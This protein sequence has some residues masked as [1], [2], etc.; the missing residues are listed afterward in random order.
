VGAVRAALVA[1][2]LHVPR[3]DHRDLVTGGPPLSIAAAADSGP[4]PVLPLDRPDGVA[5]LW[6]PPNTV[7]PG[8]R[9]PVVDASRSVRSEDEEPRLGLLRDVL[10][11]VKW[12]LS[13]R[14]GWLVGMGINLI[15]ALIYVGSTRFAPNVRGDLRIANIGLV[16]VWWVLANV[17]NTN[18]LGSDS[19][20]VVASLEDGDSLS[21]ILAIKNISLAIFLTPVAVLISVLVRVVV[22][23]WRLLPHALLAD[24]GAIFLWLGLGCV[25]SVVMP[26]RPI[27]V[28]QR[29]QRRRH[30]A[31]W[32]LC[33]ALPYVLVFLVVP[34]L[35][36]PYV[37]IYH[38]KAVG[39][40][41]ANFVVYS[42]L[43]MALGAMYWLVGLVLASW[44]GR[45]NRSRLL[46]DLR[47][48][49]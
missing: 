36:L 34:I 44:Y 32:V 17:I 48:P 4:S 20:R 12:T 31:R 19:E 21:R 40:Y 1:L 30:A 45:R 24:L 41:Q 18:Q 6:D 23:R 33:Q 10:D 29:W 37:A 7:E 49:D 22:D 14:R 39:P 42:L 11:E 3:T 2:P 35:S 9:D 15:L 8:I 38:E 16:V 5:R 25:A 46:R 27:S 28:G 43:F 47:R 13:G 26:Y